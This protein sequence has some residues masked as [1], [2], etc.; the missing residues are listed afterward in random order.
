MVG[1]RA[2]MDDGSGDALG[3]RA[4][5][6]AAGRAGG[7]GVIPRS[8]GRRQGDARRGADATR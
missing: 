2:A 1:E 6:G 8:H 4:L 7:P 5:I 3:G